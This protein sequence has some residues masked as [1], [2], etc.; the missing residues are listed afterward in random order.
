VGW[1][2]FIS[3]VVAISSLLVPIAFPQLE[4][5]PFAIKKKRD[6]KPRE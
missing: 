6:S 3:F 1:Q 2:R 5:V 4:D